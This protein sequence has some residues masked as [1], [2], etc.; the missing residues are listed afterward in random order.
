MQ[1]YIFVDETLLK[2]D[3]HD[4]GYGLL[5]SLI[6]TISELYRNYI[7][8]GYMHISRE[9][10]LYYYSYMLPL[11]QT[12]LCT[13]FGRKLILV[14]DGTHWYNDACRWLRMPLITHMILT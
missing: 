3:D 4:F 2:T 5:M 9:K 13:R 12:I 14:T 8:S 1:G 7:I 11:L 10:G 6:G